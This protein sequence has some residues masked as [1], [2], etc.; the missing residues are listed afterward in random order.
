MFTLS[1]KETH[2]KD[3]IKKLGDESINNRPALFAKIC[4]I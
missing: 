3:K 4:P 2:K 1:F